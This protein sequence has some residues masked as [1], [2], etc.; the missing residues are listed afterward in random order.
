VPTA[1]AVTYCTQADL[2]ALLSVDGHTGRLDDD[3]TGTLSATESGYL[4]K[5]INWATDRV[6]FYL[7][8]Q[9]ASTN[10]ANSWLVNNWAVICAAYWLSCRRGNPPPGSMDQ[11]YKE[12]VEDMKLVKSGQYQ[13]PDT[14]LRDS[15]FPAWSNV[16]TD[17]LYALRRVRVQ[18]PISDK[19]STSPEYQ[20]NQDHGSNVIVEW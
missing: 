8:S 1:L 15:A 19:T 5:A 2:E 18:R 9:Y 13:L 12:A 7:G 3:A 20:Q 14:A 10:L 6:N 11:L 17:F 4:T 16:R